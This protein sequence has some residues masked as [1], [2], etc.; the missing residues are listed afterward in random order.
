[1]P[2]IQKECPRCLK[3]FTCLNYRSRKYCSDKC[4]DDTKL[5][6]KYNFIACMHCNSEFA[7][8]SKNRVK[9]C[10]S[11]CR[12]MHGKQ[13]FQ[14]NNPLLNIPSGTVGAISELKVCVDLMSKGFHVYRAISP[15]APCDLAITYQNKLYRVEVTCAYFTN[16]GKIYNPK[17]HHDQTKFDIVA[18]VLKNGNISYEPELPI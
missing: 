9:F 1:M 17:R 4:K 16:S 12:A 13:K 18:L 5:A 10:S 8:G 14:K 15:C 11:N 7:Q 2:L 6:K 3:S